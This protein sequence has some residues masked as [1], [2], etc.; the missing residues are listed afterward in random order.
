M[1]SDQ[2]GNLLSLL[3]NT[4]IANRS[5]NFMT[6][7]AI[8]SLQNSLPTFLERSWTQEPAILND[9]L[10]R[11]TPVHLEFLDCWEVRIRCHERV[12]KSVS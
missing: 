2:Y 10:G 4:E 5:M 11:V 3:T 7:K 8:L 9:A 1:V 12:H 6:Y